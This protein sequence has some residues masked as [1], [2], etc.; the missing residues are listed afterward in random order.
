MSK[1]PVWYDSPPYVLCSG[2]MDLFLLFLECVINLSFLGPWFSFSPLTF[3]WPTW[4]IWVI[5]RNATSS[6]RLSLSTISYVATLYYHFQSQ[7]LCWLAPYVEEA[8]NSRL[9]C[10]SFNKRG[11][12][13]IWGWSQVTARQ[14]NL[15]TH[16]LK[17]G[18]SHVS[19]P[20]G[21]KN[22]LLSQGCTL[23][24][25]PSV[26]MVGI[27]WKQLDPPIIWV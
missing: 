12:T 4:V 15:H 26:A 20:D 11:N 21:L 25:A 2:H 5:T 22:T 23:E 3:S 14:V 16:M 10:G 19:S 17:H 7:G 9:V 8:E 24:T 6:K 1:D 27:A 18:F 13:C